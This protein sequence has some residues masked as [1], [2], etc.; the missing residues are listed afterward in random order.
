[1]TM[2]NMSPWHKKCR[3]VPRR[4]LNDNATAT[5]RLC[6]LLE[7]KKKECL[8]PNKLQMLVIYRW[9]TEGDKCLKED[10]GVRFP[11]LDTHHLWGTRGMRSRESFC[12]VLPQESATGCQK[13]TSGTLVEPVQEGNLSPCQTKSIGKKAWKPKACQVVGFRFESWSTT[14]L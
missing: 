3:L 14:S 12:F 1:M 8:T 10:R 7:R 9:H 2:K 13:N 5:Y 11:S 4:L 6:F